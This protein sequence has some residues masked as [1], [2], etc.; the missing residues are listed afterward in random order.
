MNI[1][2]TLSMTLTLLCMGCTEHVLDESC[3]SHGGPHVH[4]PL[5]G[6]ELL[7]LGK[8]GGGHNLEIL[9]DETDRL[10]VY[11]LDAH[12]ENFVR[13]GQPKL[14]LLITETNGSTTVL[15]LDA[16]ADTATGE[17]IGDSSHFRTS[18]SVTTYLPLA[19]TIKHIQIGTTE[20]NQT[21]I[22]LSGNP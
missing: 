16:V 2:V 15:G 12:A 14:E 10:S 21:S 22:T 17:T 7:P 5:M 18:G 3:Q 20:Y 13:I 1:L 11:I 8:H 19:G 9:T 4:Q 6:G